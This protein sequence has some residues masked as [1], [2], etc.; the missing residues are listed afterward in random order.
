MTMNF[1]MHSSAQSENHQGTDE[2]TYQNPPIPA[3]VEV[4]DVPIVAAT[5]AS[6]KGYGCLFDDP[7]DMTVESGKFEIVP[8]PHT[9][10]HR[11]RL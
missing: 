7:D 1:T 4:Y 9:G 6:L 5:D 2:L 11:H 8:W 10:W 3:G